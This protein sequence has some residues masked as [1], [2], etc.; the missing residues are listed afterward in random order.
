MRAAGCG[1]R[2]REQL[3][4]WAATVGYRRVWLD[5]AAVDL[6]DLPAHVARA[7][8]RCPTC[9]LRW[10]D[11]RPDLWGVVRDSGWFLASCPPCGG[12]LPSRFRGRAHGIDG[13][14]RQA[15]GLELGV[16]K[17]VSGF[18]R[19]CSWDRRVGSRPATA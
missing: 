2:A 9:K 4:A 16:L 15:D 13:V 17:S 6:D 19:S 11:Q 3:V 14:L 7:A 12:S 10:E 8:V 18:G 1:L 5:D